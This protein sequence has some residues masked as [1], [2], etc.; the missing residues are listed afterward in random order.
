[1]PEYLAAFL[2]GAALLGNLQ[3]LPFNHTKC[4]R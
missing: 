1:V 4:C 2:R 3:A